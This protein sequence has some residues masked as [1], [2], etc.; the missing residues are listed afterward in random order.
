MDELVDK[1]T[2]HMADERNLSPH[3]VKS[4]RTDLVQF[5][6][7]ASAVRCIP[8]PVSGLSHIEYAFRPYAGSAGYFA[9]H[10]P[11]VYGSASRRTYGARHSRPQTGIDPCIFQISVPSYPY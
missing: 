4:Y 1:F 5:L 3:T 7:L 10:H 8:R 2:A 9:Q 6:D 11:V